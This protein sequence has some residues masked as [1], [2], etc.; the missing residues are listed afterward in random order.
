MLSQV[1]NHSSPRKTVVRGGRGLTVA[2]LM[3]GLLAG[4]AWA[5][6]P[7]RQVLILRSL[8]RGGI[9]FDRFTTTLR[10]TIAARSTAPVTIAQFELT[11]S[12][13]VDHPEEPLISFLRSAFIN[14]SK[15]D[16]VVT[17]GGP[18]SAFARRYRAQIFRDTPVVFGVTEWRF[19]RDAPLADTETAVSADPDYARTVEEILQLRPE[20]TTVC[21]VAGAGRLTQA[22]H[23][24]LDPRF[25]RFRDRLTFI[26]SDTWSYAELLDRT[27]HLP[28]N[29]AILFLTA[30]TDAQIGWNNSE[31]TLADLAAHANAPLFAVH[32]AWLG[33]G[34]VGGTMTFDDDLAV[35]S[36]DVALRILN[37]EPPR[38]IRIAPQGNGPAVFDARQL[39]RWHIS[40]ARL[41][42]NSVVQF[43]GPGLWRDYRGTVLTAS[44]IAMLETSL[45]VGL[46]Y[47]RRARQ[48]ADGRAREQ[49]TISAHLGRQV[50]LGEMA[51]TFAHELSQPLGAIRLNVEAADK[52]IAM[53]RATP[54]QLR[55]ILQDVRKEDVRVEQIIQRHRSML[56]K[57]D[58]EKRPVDMCD[59]VREGLALL[60]H[61]TQARR[62]VVQ[63]LLP[64]TPC[65][66]AGDSVLL[67]QVIVNLVMNAMD[68]M[69]QTPGER[70]QIRVRTAIAGDHVEVSVSD[71]G[72]G[73]PQSLDG[74]LFEP[75]VT[76][77]EHGLGIGLSIVRGIVEAH[78]G[79]IQARNVP[80]GG[81]EFRFT[82][83]IAAT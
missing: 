80:E 4:P 60:S 2:T 12:E 3:A 61:N 11:P 76:T 78:G 29:S 25:Q 83:P 42:A 68:A 53:N 48:R 58:V 46:L 59:V 45:I 8:D 5:A 77:K 27:E 66:V 82:V 52:L 16:L 26:W 47:Q 9:I 65:I 32:Q 34:I 33:L 1:S 38:S 41:P 71:R 70:K 40:E 50:A 22:W 69:G 54:E 19:M 64:A 39:Q 37:G 72:P 13:F 23:D 81:A 75:F 35:S 57:K 56:K 6:A 21:V 74:R 30:V 55:D 73:L 14:G 24:E 7:G 28:A 18:A 31:R 10:G 79:T 15:P 17:V 44:A 51:A 43:R 49:L 62:V 36:A 67:Q 63:A 20:T